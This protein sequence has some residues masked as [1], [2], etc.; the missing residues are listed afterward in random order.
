[1]LIKYEIYITVGNSKD[2]DFCNECNSYKDFPLALLL[3]V[4][5]K[6]MPN[7]EKTDNNIRPSIPSYIHIT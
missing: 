3:Y 2:C 6:M 1:M 4:K 7:E 5:L